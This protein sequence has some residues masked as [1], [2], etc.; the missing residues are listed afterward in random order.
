MRRARSARASASSPLHEFLP[1]LEDL[2]V[3]VA[4]AEERGED[5]GP[6][7]EWLEDGAVLVVEGGRGRGRA[8]ELMAAVQGLLAIWHRPHRDGR[9]VTKTEGLQYRC[10]LHGQ[11]LLRDGKP[12]TGGTYL[13]REDK[14]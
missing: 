9:D 4:R 8:D 5:P 14:E 7:T 2:A 11:W 3:R 6:D 1:P 12:F 10:E 13:V